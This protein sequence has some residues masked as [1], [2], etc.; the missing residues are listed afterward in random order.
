MTT[1]KVRHTKFPLNVS[2]DTTSVPALESPV[3]YDWIVGSVVA[4]FSIRLQI[5]YVFKVDFIQNSQPRS[6]WS[7]YLGWFRQN[8]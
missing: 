6:S 3:F 7:V 5:K 1:F 8:G 4:Y 2:W